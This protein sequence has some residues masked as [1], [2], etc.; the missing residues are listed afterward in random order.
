MQAEKRGIPTAQMNE[1]VDPNSFTV[2]LENFK[3]QHGNV[4]YSEL[5]YLCLVVKCYFRPGEN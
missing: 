2:V 3:T 5:H 1:V 4:T